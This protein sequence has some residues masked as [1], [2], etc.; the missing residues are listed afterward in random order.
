MKN[1]LWQQR[2][3]LTLYLVFL[4]IAGWALFQFHKVEIHAYMNTW[5]QSSMD[6]TM[7]FVTQ[8]A[9]GIAIGL[10]ILIAL[11]YRVQ[12]GLF[13][14]FSTAFSGLITQLLKRQV[15]PHIDRPS[16]VFQDLPEYSLTFVK[17]FELHERFSFPSG[18]T[19]AAFALW[20]SAA[21]VVNKPKLAPVFAI[22]AIGIGYSRIYLSQHFLQDVVA[23]SLIGSAVTLVVAVTFYQKKFTAKWLNAGWSKYI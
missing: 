6:T 15:F 18:H 7:V 11:S 12:A 8:W 1:L 4:V 23:G 10:V 13:I 21:I 3:F 5:N 17:G 20:L 22:I 19:T 9:E 16:K 14:L 2:G